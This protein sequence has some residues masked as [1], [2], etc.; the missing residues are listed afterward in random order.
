MAKDTPSKTE[1]TE[2]KP[3]KKKQYAG[4]VIKSELRD[5]RYFKDEEYLDKNYHRVED[6][7]GRIHWEDEKGGKFYPDRPEEITQYLLTIEVLDGEKK[8]DRCWCFAPH[9]FGF[10]KDNSLF[11]V[12]AKIAK[13]IDEDF[14]LHEGIEDDNSD[15]LEKPFYFVAQPKDDP[16]YC[17]VTDFL[18][19]EAD[20]KARYSFDAEVIAEEAADARGIPEGETI[21]F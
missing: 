6:D 12:R 21:P 17:K 3:W 8:G 18:P 2:R 15:L 7:K 14:D 20:E 9:G 4:K 5:N 10:K 1:Y 13:A 19:M 16:Q 11:G